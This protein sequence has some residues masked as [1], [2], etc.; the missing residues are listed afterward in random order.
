MMRR[1]ALL[2]G[3]LAA[4][5]GFAAAVWH[6]AATEALARLAERGQADLTLATFRLTGQL[7]RYREVAVLMAD[8][9]ALTGLAR[10]GV[11]ARGEV[12]QMLLRVADRSGALDLR[13]VD[14]TGRVLAASQGTE[15][16]LALTPD[17][18]RA[19]HGA[20]GLQHSVDA[21]SG[22]R[23]FSY[24]AP[25]FSGAGP[26]VGAVLLRMDAETVEA[27][28]RGDPMPVWFSDE[29]GVIFV[30]NR[31]EM[32]FRQPREGPDVPA[33]AY[34]QALLRPFPEMRADWRGGQVIWRIEGGRYLPARALML[35]RALPVIGMTGTALVDA[36]AALRYADLQ[37]V[38]AAALMVGFGA[39][40]LALTERRRAL[41][42]RLATEARMN[43]LLDA[44]VI[45]RTRD[46]REANERLT[47]AQ[48]DLVQAGKMSALGQM[49][50]GISHELNQPLMAISSYAENATLYLDR[51]RLAEAGDNLA[52]IA[53]LARRMGRII[54]N[55]R[56]FARQ[57]REPMA[58]VDI[59]AV[60]DAALDLLQ[61]RL[62]GVAVDWSRPAAPLLVRG[63]EVRLQQ[64][65]I[66]LLSNAADAMA[67]G[68]A[69]RIGISVARA[70]DMVRLTVTDTGPGIDE[71]DRI[72]DP[73]YST[74]EVGSAEGMG[75]G[76]SISYGIVQSFGG[77]ITGR[78]RADR[79]GAEFIVDLVACAQTGEVA[80]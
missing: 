45:A 12:D 31:S 79:G 35:S 11:G 34:P 56:A 59:G 29:Y 5:F 50:A 76:L 41:A 40:L 24:A 26:V 19:G 61:Q 42:A 21:G 6:V 15:D 13:L 74:K 28:G 16:R 55:L 70:A 7:Q 1:L 48:A 72:F 46:L 17:L 69:P 38:A 43:A 4:T 25:V 20:L 23:I 39:V 52:R 71:P 32:L 73:F 3:F 77:K 27:P 47:R 54:R 80:A 2:I 18:A 67:A 33:N 63:G 62:A 37:A 65:V 53:E 44:R 75:L 51:G 57:E 14:T 36:G 58:D 68:E 60:V 78:N 10:D 64:V 22:Q 66:N 9:P 49:S 30:T 8:H